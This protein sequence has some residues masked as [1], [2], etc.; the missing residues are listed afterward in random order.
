VTVYACPPL[1]EPDEASPGRCLRDPEAVALE[2]AMDEGAA[3]RDV[4]PSTEQQ[5]LP[6]WDGLASGDYVLRATSFEQGFDR[7]FVR[8]LE[9][10]GGPGDDGFGADGSAGYL[11]PISADT[12]DYALEV[13]VFAAGD[14]ASPAPAAA[15]PEPT[16]NPSVI[17]IETPVPGQAP[18]PT[19]T[20]A[21]ATP[22]PAPIVTATP[23]A[24]ESAI[25]SS[26]AVARP[27]LGTI[28]IRILGCVDNVDAFDPANCAQAVDGFDVRLISEEGD[29][30]ELTDATIGEDGS[31]TWQ[32]VPLGTYLFQQPLLLPGTATYYAPDLELAENGTGYV[33]TIDADE[34]VASVDIFNL[35]ASPELAVDPALLD[36]DA[37]GIPD[38]DETAIYGT[39]PG[40]AD[41]DLDGVSDG[42][43]LAAGTN[44]LVADSA[45]AVDSDGDGLLDADETAFGTDPGI[46]DSDG[47]GWFDGDEVSIG[48]DP[49]D[50]NSFP[51]S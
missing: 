16:E 15:E 38:A 51:V 29:I 10:I 5:G 35:P 2:L 21:T 13:Y 1:V 37:D 41:S 22:R 14:D 46:A 25:I 43:E 30:I 32:N 45:A 28:E 39:N 4:G 40:S 31:V 36:S 24:T 49:L 42:A 34:P 47:D 33:I 12:A 3:L 18:S 6:T 23:R 20:R 50:A 19:P 7:F 26:T 11:I 44:P 27:R 17:L 48:T 9:G 8:G